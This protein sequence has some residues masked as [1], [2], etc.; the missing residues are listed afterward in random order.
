[1]KKTKKYGYGNAVAALMTV[2]SAA[3]PLAVNADTIEINGV[4]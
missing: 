3:I 1:M 4:T 2:V